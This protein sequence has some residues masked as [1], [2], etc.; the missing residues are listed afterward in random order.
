MS[1]ANGA[2][3]ARRA[4]EELAE[5]VHLLAPVVEVELDVAV[6]VERDDAGGA[7]GDGPPPA[8]APS[9][10]EPRS[11]QRRITSSEGTTAAQNAMPSRQR[12]AT[13]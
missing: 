8:R 4:P 6:D 2:H 1:P 7:R 12:R 3:C 10:P 11:F 5:V 13:R 9:L